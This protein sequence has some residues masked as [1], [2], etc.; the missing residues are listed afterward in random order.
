MSEYLNWLRQGSA[1][2]AV[3][4]KGSTITVVPLDDSDEAISAFQSI[5]EEVLRRSSAGE[6]KADAYRTRKRPGH[7]YIRVR[8]RPSDD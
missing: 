1:R 8:V 7:P 6:F 5:V 4:I 2:H 3:K